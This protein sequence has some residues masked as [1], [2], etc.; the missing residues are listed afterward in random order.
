MP[1][2]LSPLA[3]AN[4]LVCHRRCGSIIAL[5]ASAFVAAVVTGWWIRFNHPCVAGGYAAFVKLV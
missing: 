4:V 3:V 1:A 2:D 5:G